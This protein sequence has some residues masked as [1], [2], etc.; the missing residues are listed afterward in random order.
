MFVNSPNSLDYTK[1]E[2]YLPISLQYRPYMARYVRKEGISVKK[3]SSKDK[4][5]VTSNE[6]DLDIILETKELL[7]DKPVIVS[8]NASNPS[9][10]SEFEGQVDGILINSNKQNPAIFELISGDANPY[11]LLFFKCQKIWKR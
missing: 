11:G 4:T 7:N 10:V 6:E 9:V 1:D 8:N 3:S 2:G 5:N